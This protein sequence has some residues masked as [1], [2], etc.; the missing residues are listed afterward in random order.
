MRSLWRRLSSRHV[1]PSL[2]A[3]FDI[4]RGVVFQ[5]VLEHRERLLQQPLP[6][7]IL[8]FDF[9]GRLRQPNVAGL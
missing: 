5:V 4:V 7:F 3:L 6:P 1:F 9:D 2:L 8:Q